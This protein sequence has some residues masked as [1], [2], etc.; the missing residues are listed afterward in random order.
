MMVNQF[1]KE[2]NRQNIE[3]D[4]N[5][6]SLKKSSYSS[7]DCQQNLNSDGVISSS[8]IPLLNSP[9]IFM[10]KYEEQQMLSAIKKAK[11]QAR[12]KHS[13]KPL[14]DE[15]RYHI[16]N[17]KFNR[18]L[19]NDRLTKGYSR[20]AI[21]QLS[22]YYVAP[23]HEEGL[24][25]N[26]LNSVAARLFVAATPKGKYLRSNWG[27]E[28]LQ[29]IGIKLFA[30]DEPYVEGNRKF[31]SFI[32]IDTDRVWNSPE[33]CQSFF[34]QLAKDGKIASEP[35]FLVGLKLATGHFIRPHAIWMLPFGSAVWNEPS[36]KGFKSAPLNLFHSVYYGLCNALLE[37]GADAGA[38]ATSQQVKNPLSPEYHTIATQDSTFPDLSEHAEYL[39]LNHN[40]DDL[41]RKAASVQSGMKIEQSNELFNFLQKA[42][43]RIMSAWHYNADPEF[44]RNRSEGRVGAIA[45]RLHIE[46]ERVIA[47]SDIRPK[48]KD[49]NVGYLV[50]SVAEYAASKFDPEK[51]QNKRNKGAAVHLVEGVKSV[52][53]RQKI[54]AAY[55]AAVKAEASEK[56]V[57]E[58]VINAHINGHDINKTA[59]AKA[60]NISRPTVYKYWDSAIK[61]L[62][63]YI[64]NNECKTK[65]MIKRYKQVCTDVINKN[66]TS[67]EL[68]TQIELSN[69]LLESKLVNM[70]NNKWFKIANQNRVSRKTG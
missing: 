32:R 68:T 43:Y 47:Q 25:S 40:R 62:N 48:K 39:E 11:K 41:T 56:A 51:I 7:S 9:V 19:I 12:K 58:A 53:E 69:K 3:K 61:N 17:A 15:A 30:L 16:E 42:A 44:V 29:T 4:T 59:I 18:E 38:P 65:Y 36:K 63:I 27:K 50:A 33:E 31:L 14:T 46:L 26:T 66:I 13:D 24:R 70:N 64:Q 45:D 35:H 34:R 21:K 10:K 52:S 57:T 8:K 22:G 60:V 55:T 20:K 6:V 49:G 54:G 5:Y 37:A 67:K 2:V 23:V 1:K 28:S